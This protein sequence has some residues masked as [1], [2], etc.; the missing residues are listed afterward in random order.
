MKTIYEVIKRPLITEK[1]TALK[2]ES[3][4]VV[5]EVARG[6]NKMEIK[7]AVERLFDV[8]VNAVRTMIFRGKPK[9][10]GRFNGMQDKWK[11]AVV[12][13]SEGTDLDVF[14]IEPEVPATDEE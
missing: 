4:Q 12:T 9:R 6:A 13:L 3:N 10:V 8:K 1:A 7:S 5:F 14:G 2:S 11:K